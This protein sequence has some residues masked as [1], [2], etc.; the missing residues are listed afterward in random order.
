MRATILLVL[1]TVSFVAAAPHRRAVSI[2]DIKKIAISKSGE[3]LTCVASKGVEELKSL[4]LGKIQGLFGGRRLLFGAIKALA[5][6]AGKGAAVALCQSTVVPGV[7]SF[8]KAK[9]SA[10]LQGKKD[11]TGGAK[12]VEECVTITAN[13]SCQQAADAACA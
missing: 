11:V 10:L 3:V 6:N 9:I 1:L 7:M 8:A 5:C 4:A 12:I 2:G 13:A